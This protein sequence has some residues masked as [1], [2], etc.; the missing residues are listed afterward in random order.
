M[1]A[2]ASARPLGDARAHGA[3]HPGR[4]VQG[5]VVLAHRHRV[6]DDAAAGLQEQPVALAHQRADDDVEV[7]LPLGDP[8]ERPGVRAATHRLELVDDLHAAHLGAA[9]D[10]AA[11]EHRPDQVHRVARGVQVAA[12]VAHDVDDVT[13]ELVDHELV[14]A[15]RAVLADPAEVVALQVDQHDV[16]GAVLGVE[17]ELLGEVVGGER[18]AGPRAGDGA[19]LGPALG[20]ERDEALRRR[21]DELVVAEVQ[22]AGEGAGVHGAQRV[23]EVQAGQRVAEVQPL[24]EVGLEDVAGEDVLAG[25]AHDLLV[26]RLGVV[27]AEHRQVVAVERGGGGAARGTSASPTR[28]AAAAAASASAARR[29][30]STASPLSRS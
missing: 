9:G 29:S 20:V 13:V 5:L 25:A 3:Q 30:T 17:V 28:A 4:L 18:A 22:V 21:A 14:D 1:R 24:A 23:V 7:E 15:H 12:H 8:A 26:L 10:G 16:L 11:G 2:T 27:A 19:G 6:G